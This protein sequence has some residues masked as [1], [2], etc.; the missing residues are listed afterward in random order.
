MPEFA[1][2][3]ATMAG[4]PV[5][6]RLDAPSREAALRKLRN[7]GLTPLRLDEAVAAR[8][9]TSVV[10][11]DSPAAAR[12]P[13]KR[14]PVFSTARAPDH[15]DIHNFTSELAVMLRAGLPLDRALRV[16]IGMSTKPSFSTLLDDVFKSVKAGKGFSQALTPH[17]ALFGDFYINMV[18]SG[19]AG[20]QLA[21]VLARL[22]EHLER[23]KTLRESVISALIYPTI[24]VV[25]AIIS[26]VVMLGFVVPQ[27]EALFNDMGEAL[28]LPT[29]M[30]V[31]AGHLVADWGWALALVAAVGVWMLRRWLATPVGR[32]WRD[33]RMLSIPVLGE[34]VRKYELTRFAR[35]LGTLLG[36]GV[37]IV[38]AIKIATDTMGNQQLRQAVSGVAPSIKQGGRLA[39]AL[40]ASALFTPLGLNMVRLGE[41]T[42]RLD[43]MLMELARVHDAEVQSGVKRALTLIEPLLILGLGAVIAAIIVSILMGILSVNDLAI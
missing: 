12:P 42:G 43:A 27:F 36:N 11:T 39:D 10:A 8:A 13:R 2:R 14:Q 4:K 32:E 16:L 38:N 15:N 28:P 29:Q 34:V 23:V 31:A 22:A 5:D 25:V 7:Q 21:D 40:E 35:S 9:V 18:R 30:I 33:A 41:E 26:V 37:P 20:G 3:A 6:G 19:E 1:Y 17:Q 24:L